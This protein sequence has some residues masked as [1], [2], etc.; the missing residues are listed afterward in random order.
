MKNIIERILITGKS[1]DPI[2]VDEVV[3]SSAEVNTDTVSVV[4]G[5]YLSLPLREARLIF[6]REYISAQINQ[7]GGNISK[8]AQFIG[9]ERAALHR[10]LKSLGIVTRNISG[11]RVAG[12]EEDM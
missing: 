1:E 5:N 7:F 12:F 6:E 10:K 8:A 11:S 3:S 4:S 9:M 2:T